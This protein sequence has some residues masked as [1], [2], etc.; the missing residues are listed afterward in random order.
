[1]HSIY[2]EKLTLRPYTMNDS[3]VAHSYISDYE[4]T[5]F[6][7]FTVENEDETRAF[8][9]KTIEDYANDPQINYHYAIEL[10]KAKKMIGGWVLHKDYWG[11]GLGTHI[12]QTLIKFGFSELNLRRIY[13]TCDTGNIGSC[14]IMEKNGMRREGHFIR[15]RLCY[16][17][18]RDEFQY[19]ILKDEWEKSKRLLQGYAQR[20]R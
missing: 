10:S 16:G 2:T 12:V 7:L 9:K 15:N 6:L 11:Q 19:A 14:R 1:M 18:W 5:R 17:E 3:E 8:I 4:N 13:A 20:D